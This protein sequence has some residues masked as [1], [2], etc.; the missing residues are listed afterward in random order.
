[1]EIIRRSIDVI[2]SLISPAYVALYLLRP[3]DHS[4]ASKIILHHPR[5]C[6]I[7][8]ED[9]WQ[10]VT[11]PQ[12]IVQYRANYLAHRTNAKKPKEDLIN[13]FQ[14]TFSDVVRPTRCDRPAGYVTPLALIPPPIDNKV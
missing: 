4:T 9:V 11:T 3:P 6:G 7:W 1:M 2:G 14:A 13:R 12:F 8:I 5:E 10:Q